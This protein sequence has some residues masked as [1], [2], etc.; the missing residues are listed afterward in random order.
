MEQRDLPTTNHELPQ[1][2]VHTGPHRERQRVR[3]APNGY[4]ALTQNVPQNAPKAYGGARPNAGE[5]GNPAEEARLGPEHRPGP[6]SCGPPQ[7]NKKKFFRLF[8]LSF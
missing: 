8:N 2:H 5:R 7:P 6:Y 1:P 4:L 3:L